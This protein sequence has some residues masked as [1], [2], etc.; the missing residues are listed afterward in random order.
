MID[1]ARNL[2]SYNRQVLLFQDEAFT[3]A[4]DL[5]GD[6]ARA[7]EITQGGFTGVYREGWDGKSSIRLAVLARIVRECK[8]A[9]AGSK[10]SPSALLA[11]LP[12]CERLAVLLVDRFGLSYVEAA[13]VLRCSAGKLVGWLATARL[14]ASRAALQAAG[15]SGN[16]WRGE[17]TT[18]LGCVTHHPC[19]PQGVASD[20]KPLQGED[21]R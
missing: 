21:D 18:A 3:L 10:T 8:S 7:A 9:Q 19:H 1:P 16:P 11:G 20:L 15:G 17:C 6:E 2:A 4:C 13:Q 14:K 12:G 5:V